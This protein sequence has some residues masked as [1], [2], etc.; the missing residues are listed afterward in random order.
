MARIELVQSYHRALTSHVA[1]VIVTT[2]APIGISVRQQTAN[3]LQVP[4]ES[5]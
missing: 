3:K 5:M 1:T 4:L 2:F